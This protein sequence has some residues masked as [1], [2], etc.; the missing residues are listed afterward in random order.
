MKSDNI[1]MEDLPDSKYLK[2][3]RLL[4]PLMS[5]KVPPIPSEDERKA[6]GE[7]HTNPVSRM[8]FWWL[9]PI[10][11]V[12]YRR[13]LT[14]NDLFYLED[15]Q[16]TETLY[17]IFRGYLDEEIVRAWKKFQESSDDPREFKLP[18]YIIPLCLFKTMKWEY[19]RGI[20]Q[21]ILGDCASATTPLLQKKLINF[22]Q[23]KTF[24]NVGNTGQG[25][26]YAIGVCLMIFFQVL[27]LTHAFHNFQTSGAKAKAV[28]TRLLLDKSL[29][30]DARGNHYFPASKI[31]SMIST[32][33]NRIDLAVGFAPV[34]FVTI[35]PIIIC[36]ALLIWNVGVS[37][38][39]GI[40]VFIANIFVLGLLVSS[41]MLYREKAM[42]FTD[43]RVNLVKELLKNFKMIKFY[44]WE[45]SYQDRIENARN[46]E[47]KYIL[48]LQLLRNFVFSLAFAMP[49]LASMATFCTAFKITDGKSAASVF[50]SLSLFEVLSLQFI[51]APFSLNSTVDMMVSVKKI[52]QFLQHK[53]TNPNEFSVEKFSDST[54]AIKVD[55]ASFEWD[56]FE[57][58]EKD[59]EEEA[60]T[61]DNIED[62]DHNCA[63]E[64]IKGKI[65]VDYK[66]D[67]DSISSTLT[68]GV[69]TAFPGLNN[70]N[71]EI[72][73]GEFIVV[74]G[75]IGSGKS[76]L[77][78]AISGL[79]KR[80]SGEVYVDGDLLLCGY[81]WVQNSTI[82]ENILFGLP[83]NK[84]RYDQV[85]YS[86]SLQS[87]FDQ[88]Q[89]GDM[90]EVG[91]R[92]ITLSGG[93]KAR[94]NL[95][96]SVY[97]DKD[98]IL[99]DDVLSAV[100]AKVGKHIVNTC[101]LGLLGGKTRIMA[102]HQLSLIDSADRMV[103]LNGDGT[104]D[105][106]TI[107]ELRKRN[108][109]LIEL[110]QHQ[111]DPGQD[112]EDLS[113]DLDIQG[114]TDEGQQIEHADE[115]KEIVKIIGDE[116]KAVNA[117]SFQV[118]Y[119]YCKL[120]FGKLGYISML[121]FIIVSSLETFTQIF[122]NTW[123]S[124]WIEDKFVS[125][126]KNFYMGIY[127]MFAFLYAIM[128]CFFLFLLGYFCVKAAERLNI[129]ASRK[130]LHVPMSFIDI[131]PIGRVL[132]RFTKDTDVLDNELLEQ[133]IQ[134]L[135]PLFNCFG[136]IILCIVYIPWFAIGVPIILGFYFIIASYYQA[137]AREI[138]RLEA[139]KRSFVFGHFHEVLTGKDTIKAYNAIDRMKLKLNKLID[140]QN[141]A[142]YLTIANQRWLGANLAIVSF[143][144]VFV[145]SF[146][147]IFRVFN[148]SAASTGLLLTYVIAL[149]DSITM[150]M[151][152]MTQVENEFNSVERVNHYAFDLI[153]EAPYE[154]PE[155]DPAEDWPQHGKIEFKDVS[156]RYRPELPF[157]LKNI[158]L[159]VR[160]Q[161]K[162]GFCGR[163]GAGKSTFMTCLYRIT[164]YEGLISIDG[165]DISRLGL[166]RLRSKLTIIPQ[167]PVLFVG[168]IRENLDP[169]TEHSDDEL[170]EALAI[171]GL[172]DR[173]DLEVV[174]GQ[175]KIGGNDSGKL[176]KFHLVRMVEDDG[177]NFSLG[178]RQL[179]A[180]ARA[181]V[182]KSKILIL[183]EATS[184]VDY[185][186]DSKIQRTI[187]SEFRDCTI[188][189]IAHRLNTILG[190]DKIVVMDNGE[191]VEFENP[192]LL[193]MRENSV[194]RSMCEQANI[195]INDFE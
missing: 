129:K 162:I 166:H 149:T 132:N 94:I 90:T 25:V 18:I 29:T 183:D 50:S 60:K 88:F 124:F 118:Y 27:M 23:V 86:C 188:L 141:E 7:Y 140:E 102:T 28:L 31:Q 82:R 45:N 180:L 123:L 158:N 101:I 117:L 138:K 178:E 48:R 17:E 3:R 111:R 89:G 160:E 153:Q 53:D 130:I 143:S 177:I 56:T 57:D 8:M 19:S 96:R 98:I 145:I 92:G 185:A 150:I 38:L 135:S 155:N 47:M 36:I 137:S 120:A 74:T 6:Y 167:D 5:K 22:V 154:I 62:E 34:G 151:R 10:L 104:I 186:T 125:R 95:A 182:R 170:W 80:T 75:A 161:E 176:H 115:H 14:E 112:K 51:L 33:L 184:S 126:S 21:K 174:K 66:S 168:T 81:P 134:F 49:V 13:T 122:T 73:K 146:L 40:G 179:I 165:V 133:L 116:E 83:F 106:G 108:Q 97:A 156:M 152:A 65:T 71:L 169:F 52:N 79:M 42:V 195:T 11:K 175:E 109:K 59:Y 187:A 77:L 55:N 159:S 110:L 9:N 16:R 64:T 121:V 193:F 4:T 63:T 70:I 68:K 128:L 114:S 172:I 41:L 24:S 93:Q 144:M 157:V 163:T 20:L 131:S 1:A 2:Q 171:S 142:Y 191:I 84:E 30:V 100:D 91:E 72:A 54:L 43:K 87:D 32:D 181:L 35:F 127:I 37:A 67:S 61:K 173:E 105:F 44:S 69:K 58:E 148:I 192:K 76:S 189:C 139:V 119:N 26:G 113:N 85:V 12:G 194:F 15:R 190:Y 147:C 46:N 103:F 107:P 78:Q 39:V 136:I 99:L 164:E